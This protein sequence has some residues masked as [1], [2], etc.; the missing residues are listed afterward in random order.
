MSEENTSEKIGANVSNRHRVDVHRV[1][2][3]PV[4]PEYVS[5]RLVSLRNRASPERCFRLRFRVASD[6]LLLHLVVAA[7][8]TRSCELIGLLTMHLSSG[9]LQTCFS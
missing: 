4:C 5:A 6:R 1:A 8:M 2:A 7:F 9:R 3:D